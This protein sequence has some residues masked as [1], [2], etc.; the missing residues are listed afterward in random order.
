M[1]PKNINVKF[2]Q[3][4]HR[5]ENFNINKTKESVAAEIPVPLFTKMNE[6]LFFIGTNERSAKRD[7]FY[8]TS[9]DLLKGSKLTN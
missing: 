8:F 9:F 1:V 2:G 7:C 5:D 6:R 3:K 4:P